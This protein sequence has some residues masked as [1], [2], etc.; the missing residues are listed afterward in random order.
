MGNP[1][2]FLCLFSFRDCRACVP[3]IPPPGEAGTLACMHGLSPLND[4]L[5]TFDTFVLA[6]LRI[7]IFFVLSEIKLRKALR[8]LKT[9]RA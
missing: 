9:L 7:Q 8:E 5:R 4:T 2:L 1:L 6:T 3:E